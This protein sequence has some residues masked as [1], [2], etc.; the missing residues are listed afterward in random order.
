MRTTLITLLS[1][2][3][4]TA[5]GPAQDRADQDPAGQD[6]LRYPRDKDRVIAVVGG[7]ELTVEDMIQ[8][9]DRRH[10]P[11]FSRYLATRAGN[12]YFQAP[13]RF[14]ADW[15]RQFADITALRAEAKARGLD[16][17]DAEPFLSAALKRGFEAYLQTNADSDDL[18][19]ADRKVLA[20]RLTRYQ[21][22]YGMQTEVQG[23]LDFLVPEEVGDDELRDYFQGNARQFGGTVT[24][25]HI[26][27][28]HRD[29]V[30]LRLLTGEDKAKA[31]EKVA[32]IK[33]RLK[34][35]G[36]NFE[37]V[38]ARYSEDR[39]TAQRGGIFRHVSRFDTRL[40][41]V[42]C[43]AAWKL[44]DGQLTGPIESAYGLHFIKR[45]S[46]TQQRFILFTEDAKP[47]IR[48]TRRKLLQE[49]LLL[50]AREKRGVKLLY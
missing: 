45:L 3:A 18:S 33:A 28:H 50:E 31:W 37:D 24:F 22:E 49:N 17:E 2:L 9:L 13:Q 1:C 34:D 40:P 7:E 32:D 16:L 46:M 5:A 8:H 20:A 23:W 48:K 21:Q 41:A 10:A 14:G 44:E 29:P 12:L 6:E 4:I 39:K 38:A 43:R 15:V 19:A 36:S 30:T 25:S 42:L 27:V 11:G 26:L 35:D 47:V